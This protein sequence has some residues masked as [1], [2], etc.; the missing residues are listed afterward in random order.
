MFKMARLGLLLCCL[1]ALALA[2]SNAATDELLQ[3]LQTLHSMQASF[4]QRTL[5]RDG[6]VLQQLTGQIQVARPG[7]MR[8]HTD[9]PYPQLVVSDG[10]LL[11]IYDMDLEQVTI[12]HMDQRVQQTPALLLSGQAEAIR[13]SFNVKA[14]GDTQQRTYRLLPQDNSQLFEELRFAYQGETLQ[15][16]EILDAAG[17]LT[18]IQFQQ[19]AVNQTMDESAF[20]FNVPEG[21]DVIDGRHD[22]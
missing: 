15:R 22:F 5:A 8:W 12:R 7:K 10:E 2:N 20:V 4:E 18:E 19:S 16:M 6:K 3:R 17:Q 9:D 13:D 11:W 14:E 21:V 1:P